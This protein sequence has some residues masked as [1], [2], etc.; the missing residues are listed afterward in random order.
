MNTT[1]LYTSN[2][3]QFVKFE[4]TN[5]TADIAIFDLTGRQMFYKTNISTNS[6]YK[7]NLTNVPNIYVVKIIYK[8]G[9]TV[10]KKTIN[11]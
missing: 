5:T 2:N 9:K 6:D 11:K 3:S 1:Y 4:Q 10:T 8:D 7:L